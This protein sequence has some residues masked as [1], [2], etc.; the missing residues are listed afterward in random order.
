MLHKHGTNAI[1]RCIPNICKQ[2]IKMINLN[3]NNT[4]FKQILVHFQ[5]LLNQ[6]LRENMFRN[7]KLNIFLFK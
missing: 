5:V 7:V 1:W 4:N 6:V 2:Q 3:Y